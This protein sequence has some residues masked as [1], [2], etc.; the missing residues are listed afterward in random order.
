MIDNTLTMQRQIEMERE[1]QKDTK[2]LREGANM[3]QL[4]MFCEKKSAP[5]LRCHDA[6]GICI[7]YIAQQTPLDPDGGIC[8]HPDILLTTKLEIKESGSWYGVKKFDY[9]RT[10][11][12]KNGKTKLEK[13]TTSERPDNIKNLDR[14]HGCSWH[15]FKKRSESQIENGK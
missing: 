13:L 2:N 14:C 15:A 10:R 1:H 12:L 3:K 7:H 6:S 8:L 11:R 4:S 5:I 9:Y